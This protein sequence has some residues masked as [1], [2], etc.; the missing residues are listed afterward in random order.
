MPLLRNGCWSGRERGCGG[1]GGERVEAEGGCKQ[2]R[3][4]GRMRFYVR[5]GSI[6]VRGDL[7][8]AKRGLV[9]LD[10]FY[11]PAF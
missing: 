1:V 2:T 6:D 11:Q 9:G 10:D 3:T 5:F 4:S 8:A 7:S